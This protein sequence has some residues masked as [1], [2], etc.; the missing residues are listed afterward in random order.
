MFRSILALVQ[1][2]GKRWFFRDTHTHT[3]LYYWFLKVNTELQC[4]QWQLFTLLYNLPKCY[5]IK[6]EIELEE[7]SEIDPN[8]RF[9]WLIS[10]LPMACSFLWIICKFSSSKLQS[11]TWGYFWRWVSILFQI[12][13]Q[14]QSLWQ[15]KIKLKL[16]APYVPLCLLYS[17]AELET[18]A[19]LSAEISLSQEVIGS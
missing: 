9:V 7:L 4:S 8:A 1:K 10:S 16:S 18:H 17:I 15:S 14:H 6:G 13:N 11:A 3:Q 19:I 12:F 5:V 2:H